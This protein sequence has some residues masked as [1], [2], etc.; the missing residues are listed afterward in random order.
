[1]KLKEV[2]T[3]VFLNPQVK[4]EAI[5]KALPCTV[6]ELHDREITVILVMTSILRAASSWQRACILAV[7]LVWQTFGFPLTRYPKL[8]L[9]KARASTNSGERPI[10]SPQSQSVG[11]MRR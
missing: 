1:M 2:F 6:L 5:K 4:P 7:A 10:S 3:A 11:E 8:Q 9:Q